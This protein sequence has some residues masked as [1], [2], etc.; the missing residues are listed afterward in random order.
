MLPR[1]SL[2]LALALLPH[3]TVAWDG[4]GHRAACTRAWNEMTPPARAAVQEILSVATAEDFAATCTWADE[5]ITQRPETAAWHAMALPKNARAVDLA[6]HCA[7]PCVV[8]EID[9][10]AGI[11]ATR[12][13]KD[14]RAEAL[15]FLAHLVADLHQPLNLGFAADRGGRDIAVTFLGRAMDMHEVWDSALLAA[16]NPPS[17][18]Y[19]PFLQ[20][21]TDTANRERWM[22]GTP[23]AWA[24]ET[25]W[26]MRDTPTGYIGNP[27]GLALDEV[28]VKQN[29]LVAVDQIDKSG[30]R[31]AFLLNGMF[32]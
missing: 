16:Q 30:M 31:L 8:S 28:Y 32:K 5:I 27:G 2:C 20:E 1:L 17:H 14:V 7:A 26:L 10:H 9:R 18:G 15:K 22:T 25:L 11:V 4:A 19:T 23:A 13:S 29:Y 3:R 24:Q 21:M 6:R 12:A